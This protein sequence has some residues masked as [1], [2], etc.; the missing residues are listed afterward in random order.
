LDARLRRLAILVHGGSKRFWVRGDWDADALR[1]IVH[2]YV[3][4]H[5][6]DDDA[7]LDDRRDRLSQT[8]QS[9]MRS[10]AAIHWFGREDYELPDRASSLPNVSRHGHAFHRSR[11]V[12][13]E[14]MDRRSRIVWKPH[15]CLPTSA[16]QPNQSL[17]RE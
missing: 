1:D 16:L 12:S 3:I 7:V 14:G 13:S 10:G 4:E 8:G 15:M 2:D 5:L 11:V 9:V 17:R 6:A